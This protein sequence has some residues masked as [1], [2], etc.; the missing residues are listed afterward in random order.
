MLHYPED[1]EDLTVCFHVAFARC[2]KRTHIARIQKL[3]DSVCCFAPAQHR[4]VDALAGGR[5]YHAR[6]VA[7]KDHV[8]AIVP[9]LER[10]QWYRCAFLANQRGAVQPDILAQCTN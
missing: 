10:F 7:S 8:A 6:G 5:C 4:V 9:F 3:A 2:R 1:H